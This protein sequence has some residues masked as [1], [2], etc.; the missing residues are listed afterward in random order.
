[1][2]KSRSVAD[3]AA[4]V[5]IHRNTIYRHI[6]LGMVQARPFRTWILGSGTV[7]TRS[8]DTSL[9][10][11]PYMTADDPRYDGLVRVVNEAV[12]RTLVDAVRSDV[13]QEIMVS[14]LSGLI[15][16]TD[17][18]ETVRAHIKGHYKLFPIKDY[19]TVSLD[20]PMRDGSDRRLLDTLNAE[21]IAERLS[22]TWAANRLTERNRRRRAY[23]NKAHN[24][25]RPSLLTANEYSYLRGR[26][27]L[28]K[29]RVRTQGYDRDPF[30]S[31]WTVETAISEEVERIP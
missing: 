31:A 29:G 1:M 4:V 22:D 20:T 5:G 13:C 12:P 15:A 9:A 11:W 2:I 18:K 17:I 14:V 21:D 30:G 8:G 26:Y 28:V 7:I 10:Y 19:K 25:T 6:A 24:V 3:V 16:E 27:Q 23:F